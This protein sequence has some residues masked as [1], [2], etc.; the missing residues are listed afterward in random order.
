[1]LAA[2]PPPPPPPPPPLPSLP[3]IFFIFQIWILCLKKSFI[4]P[5]PPIQKYFFFFQLCQNSNLS[6][7]FFLCQNSSLT[8]ELKI[9]VVG[10]VLK[11]LLT[12]FQMLIVPY[13]TLGT[14][15]VSHCEWPHISW[16]SDFALYFRR[17]QIWRHHTLDT[18]SVS[19][20][21]N[22][23]IL[24]GGHC[25]LYF[26]VQWFCLVSLTLSYRKTSY[27]SLKQTAGLTSCPWTT[28]LVISVLK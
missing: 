5:P 21:V 19:D 26:M 10:Y 22:D 23:L 15:I 14:C 18:C 12:Y 28:I 4:P 25:D 11:K 13:F 9:R 17:Y 16:S 6:E 20:T 2:D 3:P 27:R 24:F 8:R 7:K 1:M